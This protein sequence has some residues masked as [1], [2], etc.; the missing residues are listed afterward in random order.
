MVVQL[1]VASCLC[2]LLLHLNAQLFHLKQRAAPWAWLVA[3]W[4]CLV[5]GLHG[6]L[7]PWYLHKIASYSYVPA[8]RVSY[9]G[10][11]RCNAIICAL[12]SDGTCIRKQHY[13]RTK[14]MLPH[15]WDQTAL[16]LLLG[17]FLW[18]QHF[19]GPP[20]Q[21]AVSLWNNHFHW[22]AGILGFLSV[23]S[24]LAGIMLHFSES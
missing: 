6:P 10:T 13:C 7:G 8:L 16:H 5:L 12:M 20:G 11:F 24:C 14:W 23:S 4:A 9:A 21:W 1:P 18:F 3:P 15:A 2:F 17:R 19:T 22:N